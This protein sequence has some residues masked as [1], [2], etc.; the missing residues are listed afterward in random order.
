[1]AQ[2]NVPVVQAQLDD[3]RFNLAQ[4]RMTAPADGYVV[5]WQVQEGTMVVPAPLA[6]AG[7][8]ISTS[9]TFVGASFP[10]NY[11]QHVQPGDEVDVVLDPYPGRLFKARVDTVITAT[12][13]G[14]FAP[15]GTIPDA[16]RVGS[17]GLLAVK[18]SLVDEVPPANLPLGAG[19]AVAI[20][21]DR[22]KPVHVIS[23]V[24]I[25]MKKWLLYVVPS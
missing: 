7:T 12:G 5:N 3:A 21:T 20:Y 1:M 19:G 2:S 24:T 15:S 14:Q 22:G 13:E 25:R 17:Q 8:F 6:A 11:L 23:K 16:S 4:C 9:E 18:I 10:Q